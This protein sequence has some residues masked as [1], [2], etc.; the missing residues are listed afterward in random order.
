MLDYTLNWTGAIPDAAPV[1]NVLR[2]PRLNVNIEYSPDLVKKAF[3]EGLWINLMPRKLDQP[4]ATALISDEP[5][6]AKALLEVNPL[7]KQFLPYFTEGFA[8]GDSMLSEAPACFVRG[9][10]HGNRLLVIV[11]NDGIGGRT[12]DLKSD[13]NMWLP[14]ALRYRQKYY[15]STGVIKDEA[16]LNSPDWTVK[17]LSLAALELAFFE[18]EAL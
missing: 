18:I 13:L 16:I 10:Q 11:L 7:R 14:T 5:E 4:N 6:L 8:L 17:T 3:C 1:L 2:S 15:D 12:I 9:Y